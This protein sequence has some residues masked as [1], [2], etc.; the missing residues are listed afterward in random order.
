MPTFR[1][2]DLM[3]LGDQVFGFVQES[4]AP[5]WAALLKH[6]DRSLRR[7]LL[8][9]I[10]RW[11]ERI[12]IIAATHVRDVINQ[13][14][15]AIMTNKIFTFHSDAAHGWLA[16]NYNDIRAAELTPSDFSAY[17]YFKGVTYFLEEDCDAAVFAR[18]WEAKFGYPTIV[19]VD[20][21]A[22]SPIRE[23]SSNV[24]RRLSDTISF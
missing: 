19:E 4:V 2:V 20:D 21:G 17:S 23:Y 14:E 13:A 6:L 3:R 1:T 9:A 10:V 12:P 8:G 15:E 22:Y 24:P 18:A 16:V 5:R 11:V 7:K